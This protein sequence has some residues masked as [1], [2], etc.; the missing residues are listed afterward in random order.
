[1][2]PE[3]EAFLFGDTRGLDILECRAPHRA[4]LQGDPMAGGLL[5]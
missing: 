4:F 1:M 2:L 5:S 3:S